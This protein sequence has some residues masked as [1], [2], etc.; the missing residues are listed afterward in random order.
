MTS[1]SDTES[2]D[3]EHESKN[4]RWMLGIEEGGLFAVLNRTGKNFNRLNKL[5]QT[6]ASAVTGAVHTNVTISL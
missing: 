4:K 2:Q 5:G 6:G 3:K 1:I